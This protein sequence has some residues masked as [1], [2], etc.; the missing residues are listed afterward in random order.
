M[1]IQ[2]NILIDLRGIYTKSYIVCMILD[3]IGQAECCRAG[4][5][6]YILEPAECQLCSSG[7]HI[8]IDLE[9]VISLF[10]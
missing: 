7:E 6:G 5:V 9:S 10:V 1:F 3:H 4:L 8:D 2:T